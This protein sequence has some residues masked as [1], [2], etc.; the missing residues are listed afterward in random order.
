LRHGVLVVDARASRIPS[1]L[2][3]VATMSP[4]LLVML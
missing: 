4:E 1:E 3:R 2:C